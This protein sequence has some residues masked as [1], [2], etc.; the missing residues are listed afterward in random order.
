MPMSE[1]RKFLSSETR[2]NYNEIVS[3]LEKHIKD[4][5]EKYFPPERFD[6][7][8]Y[9]SFLMHQDFDLNFNLLLKPLYAKF[10][11]DYKFSSKGDIISLKSKNKIIPSIKI[12]YYYKYVFNQ[13]IRHTLKIEEL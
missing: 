5:A 3:I 6:K 7:V 8:T 1:I 11:K 2:N 10:S 13:L 12:E 4:S 9:I